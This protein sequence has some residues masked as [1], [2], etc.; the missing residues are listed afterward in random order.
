MPNH[1]FNLLE[2]QIGEMHNKHIL[3]LGYAY[4]ADSDDSRN[5]PSEDLVKL[6]E[7]SGVK[8]SIHDPYISKY[9]GEVYEKARECDAAVLM[10]AHSEYEQIDLYKLKS[11]MKKSLIIDG[12]NLL[13]KENAKVAGLDLIR[14]GDR[15]N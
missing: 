13:N 14:L 8:V 12:R 5:S 3:V 7:T 1:I 6:L 10:T 11:V 9:N 4:L 15:S 2:Q